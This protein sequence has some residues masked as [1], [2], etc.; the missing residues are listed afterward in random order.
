MFNSVEC[1]SMRQNVV[2]T[3]VY[4]HSITLAVFHDRPWVKPVT[5]VVVLEPVVVVKSSIYTIALLYKQGPDFTV[6]T[7]QKV[8]SIYSSCCRGSYIYSQQLLWVVTVMGLG[9]P[10]G[11][12]QV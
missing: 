8:I 3:M 9:I 11:F 4:I 6:M 5:M 2:K 10:V 1:L 7:V 12:T